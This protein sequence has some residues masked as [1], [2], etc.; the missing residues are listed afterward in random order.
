MLDIKWIRD[1]PK[2]LV[3]ALAKRSWSADEAQSTVDELIKKDEARREHV[4]ELQTKQERRNAASK[5]IGNAMRSG[6]TALAEKLKAEVGDIKTFIQNGEAR[7]REL[8]K[9]LNDALAVL[10]NVPLDDVPV[11]KDEHDNVVKHI[12]GEVPTRPNWVKE[13]F[14]IGEALGMMD[15]ERAA[16]LSGSRFTVLKSGLARMERA[17]GQFMLDLHTTEHGY[18]E[19]IPPLMVRDEVLFG[20]NQLPKFE[21]DLFFVQHG[22]GRLGLI[23]TAEVPLTNLV[24][25]EITAHEK[26]PLRYTAL[27]PC[28]RSEAGSAGRDTRGMLRQHQFYKV[29]LVS[30][31]DQESSLAEHERMTQCAEEVLKRLELP[32]RTMVLCTGDMGFGA[33][34]TYDI[35]VWLPGQNAYREISSC[36]VCGDFQARRMDARYKDRDGK[37]NRFV[38]TLNGS[39]TAVGRALIAV[40][41]NYQ[42]EDGSVTI[43]E[44]LRPYMGGL[45]KIESK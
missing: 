20:T 38:H 8:D 26:L 10:P 35:E 40:I 41:E 34:K 3:E 7:E 22:D 28:F 44:V 32:F 27:T 39:G 25:E 19:V 16:K 5:E 45:A 24:R 18:E 1:N 13:H 23:P 29:E 36:S 43:P 15:F 12:V 31:T 17:I 14:E 30:V 4:T 42:N 9:T 21:D 6:D 11:G 33:R 2:A 37:G